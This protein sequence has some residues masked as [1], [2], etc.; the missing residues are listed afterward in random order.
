M[1]G[2]VGDFGGGLINW[3]ALNWIPLGKYH[4]NT[5]LAQVIIGLI[6]SAIWYFLFKFL[7]EKYNLKTP[8]RESDDDDA[9]LYSKKEYNDMK[10]KGVSKDDSKKNKNAEKAESFLALL[11]GRENIEDVTNCAN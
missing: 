11:G 6:F 7:I 10:E 9:K 8:G 5:Y 3:F 4:F 1:F 2:V